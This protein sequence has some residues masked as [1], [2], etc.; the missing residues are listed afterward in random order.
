[1][2]LNIKLEITQNDSA[3]LKGEELDE[4]ITSQIEGLELDGWE[5]SGVQIVRGKEEPGA[6]FQ[7]FPSLM[8]ELANMARNN[9]N[10]NEP[11]PN[12]PKFT[13]GQMIDYWLAEFDALKRSDP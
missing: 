10:V 7:L 13:N 1:M 3:F 11:W 8:S 5:V 2:K 9:P 4:A 12:N 6:A